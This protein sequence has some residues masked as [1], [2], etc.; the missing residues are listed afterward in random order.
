MTPY[1]QA[2]LYPRN[3]DA[4]TPVNDNDNWFMRRRLFLTVY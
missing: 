3:D 1:S 4:E 2:H